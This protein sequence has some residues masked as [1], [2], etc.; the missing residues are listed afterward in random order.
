MWIT[1]TLPRC[2]S[3]NGTKTIGSYDREIRLLRCCQSNQRFAS[4]THPILPNHQ[5][6]WNDCFKK[7]NSPTSSSAE[8][9]GSQTWW[10]SQRWEDYQFFITGV[11]LRRNGYS[12]GS[13]GIVNSTPHRARVT[14]ANIFSRVAQGSNKQRFVVFLK[15]VILTSA[16]HDAHFACSRTPTFGARYSEHSFSARPSRQEY[17][18]RSATRT[19]VR[20]FCR[21]TPQTTPSTVSM[22]LG[23]SDAER[24]WKTWIWW[25]SQSINFRIL[26]SEVCCS[27]HPLVRDGID[28]A[29]SMED[30]R[31][32]ESILGNNLPAFETLDPKIANSLKKFLAPNDFRK[33]VFIEEQRTQRENRFLRGRQIAFIIDDYFRITVHWGFLWS[34]VTSASGRQ[35]PR[36]RY[37]MRRSSFINEDN[38]RRWCSVIWE[39]QRYKTSKCTMGLC[40]FPPETYAVSFCWQLIGVYSCSFALAWIIFSRS[41]SFLFAVTAVCDLSRSRA[42]EWPWASFSEGCICASL[43]GVAL[44]TFTLRELDCS[45]HALVVKTLAWNNNEFYG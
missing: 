45:R 3:G 37:E 34:H 24:K 31:N 1:L 44:G 25:G 4:K 10:N 20:P 18:L 12:F 32:F 7:V 8:W 38:S 16:C 17:P 2:T 42:S 29:K 27:C 39:N 26:E 35:R 19:Y 14:Y 15:T 43:W 13:D 41:Y 28:S 23:C 21:T 22:N 40:T 30:V 11:S 5:N 33:K 9:K 6:S 36:I